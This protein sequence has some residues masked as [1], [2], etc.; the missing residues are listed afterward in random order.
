[1]VD[2]NKT[3]DLTKRAKLRALH[4]LEYMDRSEHQL[5]EKL[6]A[7]YPEDV[8]NI[9]MAYVKSF[10]YVNDEG[11]AKRY[12]EN[13]KGS[14]SKEEIKMALLQKGVSKELIS[15]AMQE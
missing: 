13:R 2:L 10:G 12:I 7:D 1:M 9:A 15:N 11:Y 3:D 14:K 6:R 5:Y 4:L 8:V